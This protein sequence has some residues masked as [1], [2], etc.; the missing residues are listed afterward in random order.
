MIAVGDQA[1]HVAVPGISAMGGVWSLDK[2]EIRVVIRHCHI[3]QFRSLHVEHCREQAIGQQVI[4]VAEID[5]LKWRGSILGSPRTAYR[6]EFSQ[7]GSRRWH[8]IR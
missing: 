8:R 5:N 4:R 3:D 1:D 2:A 7:A 6:N